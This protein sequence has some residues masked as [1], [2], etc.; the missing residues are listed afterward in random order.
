MRVA[1]ETGTGVRNLKSSLLGRREFAAVFSHE[2]LFG[3]GVRSKCAR[4][5]RTQ[6]SVC[7][8]MTLCA[9]ACKCARGARTHGE[10]EV[11]VYSRKNT[12]QFR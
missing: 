11:Q 5:V 12:R 1:V 10:I 8:H 6:Q 7:M 3:H 4:G 2:L 9:G